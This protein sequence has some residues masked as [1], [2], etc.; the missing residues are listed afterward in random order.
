M[1]L[2]ASRNGSSTGHSPSVSPFRS[3]RLKKRVC[4]S[5]TSAPAAL[6]AAAMPLR[7]KQASASLQL[8]SVTMT[9]PAPA[10]LHSRTISATTSGFVVAACSGSRSHAMFG[11]TT[12]VSP[13]ETNRAMPPKSRSRARRARRGWPPRP[14]PRSTPGDPAG[15]RR[16]GRRPPGPPRPLPGAGSGP[17]GT[18]QARASPH[19]RRPGAARAEGRPGDRTLLRARTSAP[20][21]GNMPGW[22]YDSSGRR[23]TNVRRARKNAVVDARVPSANSR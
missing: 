1:S 2:F 14:E 15:P 11:L 10:A 16:G 19:S 4:G 5:T 17:P 9:E 21:A 6:A 12:T 20:S 23:T 18:R 22:P 13:R 8:T 7:S 3:T